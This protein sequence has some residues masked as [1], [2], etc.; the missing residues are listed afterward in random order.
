MSRNRIPLKSTFI[1]I[2]LFVFVCINACAEI[3]LGTIPSPPPSAKLRV[4]IMPITGEQIAFGR[5]ISYPWRIPH[6]QFSE[7]TFRVIS[8]YLTNLGVYEIIPDEDIRAVLGT[9]EF[10]G[11]QWVRNDLAL[12]KQVG[13]V[14]HADYAMIYE[15]RYIETN[16]VPKVVFV[17]LES[18]T[19]YESS[20]FLAWSATNREDGLSDAGKIIQ[21]CYRQ[22][23]YDAKGDLLATAIR[24]GRLMPTEDMKKL[25]ARETKLA[26]V[27][28]TPVTLPIGGDKGSSPTKELS[29]KSVPSLIRPPG[30][31][32]VS[33]PQ[34]SIKPALP[35][36]SVPQPLSASKPPAV[37]VTPALP[38]EPLPQ[39]TLTDQPKAIVK[40]SP[41]PPSDLPSGDNRR[42][43]EKKFRKELQSESPLTD[44]T[45]LV[46]HD[47][48]TIER[49]KVVSLILTEALR[50]EF[51]ILGR[52]RLVNREDMMQM[53]E[54]HKLQQSGLVDEKQVAQ[55]GKWLAA[56]EA[57]TGRL[58][59]LGN[60]YVLQ[61]KRTDIQT[62]GTLGLGSLRCVAGHEDELL[63]GMPDLARR[64]VGL[65][66]T[67][68]GNK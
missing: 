52:F 17:N 33:I 54:E 47:F 36:P 21:G 30:E 42:D 23:F 1:P 65:Y 13:K 43:F 50:E 16:F 28:K 2:M 31:S 49:L 55:L 44:K 35:P 22:I 10:M 45:K 19:Q 24:K 64:L 5:G 15:R 18:G 63:S 53:L 39:R 20:G 25:P 66:T 12:L 4:F 11:W 61:A 34:P 59:V 32:I 29:Q 41:S 57:V 37:D 67:P 48:D 56:N 8:K 26:S 62:L 9:Q 6:N 7:N 40:I 3:R 68:N 58:A 60:T 51:F 38:K 46:V 27:Q 14:L